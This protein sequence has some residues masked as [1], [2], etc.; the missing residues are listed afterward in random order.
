[1]VLDFNSS[2]KNVQSSLNS[3]LILMIHRAYSVLINVQ[4][5][6]DKVSEDSSSVSLE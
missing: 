1:M 6:P 3:F 5:R 2:I 4:Q